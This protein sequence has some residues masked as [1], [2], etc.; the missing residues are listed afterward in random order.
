MTTPLNQA[1]YKQKALIAKRYKNRTDMAEFEQAISTLAERNAVLTTEILGLSI[2][3]EVEE[4]KE[5]DAK[6][7]AMAAELRAAGYKVEQ[8]VG[9]H[10]GHALGYLFAA[11]YGTDKGPHRA[12]NTDFAELYANI[13]VAVSGGGKAPGMN[14]PGSGAGSAQPVAKVPKLGGVHGVGEGWYRP[15]VYVDQVMLVHDFVISTKDHHAAGNQVWLKHLPS[16]H[17]TKGFPSV[18]EAERVLKGR[19]KVHGPQSGTPPW[20]E[21]WRPGLYPNFK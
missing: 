2:T 19:T 1:K 5:R 9:G 7:M 15:I 12:V 11:P 4:R 6:H 10:V 14:T 21:S 20:F 17:I 8:L 18:A 13:G 3:I 16:G